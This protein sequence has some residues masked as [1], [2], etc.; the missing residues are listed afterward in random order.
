MALKAAF[1][2]GAFVGALTVLIAGAAV[3]I[4]AD[5]ASAD[6]LAAA[7]QANV[8]PSELL[9]AMDSTGIGDPFRYLRAVG[10]LS[11]LAPLPSRPASSPTAP[12]AGNARVECIIA[13]ESGGANVANSRG[14]GAVGVA[15]YLPSTFAAHAREMGHPEW[16][17]WRPDEAR[18]VAAHDLAL[19]R[20][21][22]WT[23]GGC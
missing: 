20:R 5:P 17:P 15:Q 14:S 11:P 22:Q 9:A 8:E 3:G 12:A 1:L 23:V 19:G 6:V 16:S 2:S 4:H 10:E 18:A 7:E 21:A 13:K